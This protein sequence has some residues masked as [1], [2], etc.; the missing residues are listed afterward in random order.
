MTITHPN[1]EQASKVSKP[2]RDPARVL[3]IEHLTKSYGKHTVVDDLC[4][5]VEPGRVTGFLGPNGSGKSTTMKILL[6][7]ASADSGQATVGGRRYED[8]DSPSRTVG[9]ALETNSFHPGRSGR[10]HLRILAKAT[11][12]PLNRVD[13]TLELVGLSEAAD[14]QAGTYSL[15]MRQRLGV[16]VALLGDPPILVLDE[17]GNG[18]DPQGVRSLRE[19]LRGRAALGE[20]VFVSSHLLAEVEQLA[21]D[22]V[23]I[24]GG[25]LVAQ[26][27]LSELQTEATLVRIDDTQALRAV[28]ETAGATC[29]EHGGHALVVKG[30]PTAEI[31]ERAFAAGLVLHELSPHAGS[32]EEMFLSWTNTQRDKDEEVIQL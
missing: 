5:T 6:G 2:S 24:D 27:A 21:D 15:G 8:L 14:R 22:V 7:L 10:N 30:I 19:L 20:T 4:F 25:R 11:G 1:S 12:I 18:L 32:L 23:V 29:E 26:G 17:P 13:E 31:G 9:A 28:L 16:A 3:D